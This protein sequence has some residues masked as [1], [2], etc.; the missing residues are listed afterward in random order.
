V[1]ARVKKKRAG[2]YHPSRVCLTVNTCIGGLELIVETPQKDGIQV[3]HQEER[4]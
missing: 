3:V 1:A 2:S 4:E